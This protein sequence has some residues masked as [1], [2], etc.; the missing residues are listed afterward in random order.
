MERVAKLKKLSDTRRLLRLCFT[1]L[2]SASQVP[3]EVWRDNV[4]LETDL[5]T[6]TLLAQ[7]CKA[8]WELVEEIRRCNVRVALVYRQYDQIPLA[9]R[10]LE[11]CAHNGVAEAM[12]HIAY[13][14]L[15][16]GFGI[17][18][19]LSPQSEWLQKA[20]EHGSFI[21]MV[22]Y[23]S[24]IQFSD[25]VGFKFYVKRVLLSDDNL[26]LGFYCKNINFDL[27]KCFH[28]WEKSAKEGNEFGQFWFSEICRLTLQTQ[29]QVRI[30][31]E[32]AA[33][34]GLYVAQC[35]MNEFDKSW[36]KRSRKQR[37]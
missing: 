36:A 15:M 8:F 16:G 3:L 31:L 22:W 33:N 14:E 18:F 28:F 17:M 24:S 11:M 5:P 37:L 6:M 12:F 21:A 19:R 35:R 1:R 4:V 30:W 32:R 2:P 9:R 26:A 27:E 20:A 7:T 29:P 10:C 34:Q 23:A 25:P 13:S